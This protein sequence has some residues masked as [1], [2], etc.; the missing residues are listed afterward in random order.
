[1]SYMQAVK[2][3]VIVEIIEKENKTESGLFMPE[4]AQLEPQ[5][6]GKVISKGKEID[7][8]NE[9]DILS[10]NERAGMDLVYNK[11]KLKCLNIAEVYAVIKE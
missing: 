4:T 5:F 6:Y 3:K 11:Q 8:V 1:M 2:D 9:G 10:F 7:E